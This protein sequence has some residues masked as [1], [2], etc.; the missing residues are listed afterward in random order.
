MNNMKRIIITLTLILFL[1]TSAWAQ[2][3][4]GAH[5]HDGFFLR[6]GTGFGFAAASASEEGDTATFKGGS[7]IFDFGVGGVVVWSLALHANIYNWQMVNPTYE[8]ESDDQSISFETGNNVKGRQVGFGLGLSYYFMP[9]NIYLSAIFGGGALYL[10]VGA[11]TIGQTEGGLALRF[12]AG[13]EWWASDNWGLGLAI[14]SD[15]SSVPS[16]AGGPTWHGINWGLIFS[17]T[18]D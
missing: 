12:M 3:T 9:V 5:T 6:L 15:Y 7:S 4:P 2:N 1:G 11:I 8:Y 17:A 18:Y 13:K 16:E 10:D 14:V